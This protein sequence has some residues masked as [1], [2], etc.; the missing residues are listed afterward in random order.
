ML[1]LDFPL[2]CSGSERISVEKNFLSLSS[3]ISLPEKDRFFFFLKIKRQRES[4]LT[5]QSWQ[6]DLVCF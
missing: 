3:R 2:F 6:E 5:I 1:L 4:C